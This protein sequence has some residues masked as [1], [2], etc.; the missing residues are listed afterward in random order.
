M[1][2]R[3]EQLAPGK[4]NV[5]VFERY[6]VSGDDVTVHIDVQNEAR[7]SELEAITRKLST[8]EVE[9]IHLSE[10]EDT[11]WVPPLA[12]VV[13]T[14]SARSPDS[15]NRRL[16]E[17]VVCQW[18]ETVEGWMEST[19]KIAVLRTSVTP[20]HQYFGGPHADSVTIE[21]AYRE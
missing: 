16:G 5:I 14:V 3:R 18:T 8:G 11:H 17:Q 6:V 7:L 9:S 12:D 10:M 15:R 1:S 2:R 13:L 4:P 20:C 19:E 21:L